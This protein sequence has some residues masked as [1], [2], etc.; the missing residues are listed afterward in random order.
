M[1]M[2]GYRYFASSLYGTYHEY[3]FIDR[4]FY[5]S[6]RLI[7][8]LSLN[9]TCA[10]TLLILFTV[11]GV[12][13]LIVFTFTLFFLNDLPKVLIDTT[14]QRYLIRFMEQRITDFE[15]EGVNGVRENI[16][17]WGARRKVFWGLIIFFG[18][19][20]LLCSVGTVLFLATGVVLLPIC[21]LEADD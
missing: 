2:D 17:A 6:G 1:V 15:R 14:S 5:V 9:L 19:P 11:S 18:V 16:Q 21:K 7:N 10:A 8:L 13:N 12:I 4:N 3:N 20:V